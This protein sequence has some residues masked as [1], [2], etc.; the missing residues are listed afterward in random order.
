MLARI[1]VEITTATNWGIRCEKWGITLE[2]KISRA[3][4]KIEEVRSERE[5]IKATIQE[6]SEQEKQLTT[7]LEQG[8]LLLK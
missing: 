4:Q 8:E 6:L 5:M 1:E 3:T 2:A 7:R